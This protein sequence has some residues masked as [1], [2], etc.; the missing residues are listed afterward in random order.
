MPRATDILVVLAYAIVA[1][2]AAIAFDRFGLMSSELAWIMGAVVFLIAGQVHAAAARI[3]ERAETAR[4]I[5]SLKAAN[6]SLKRALEHAEARLDAIDPDGAR[7]IDIPGRGEG[8][9]TGDSPAASS[10]APA[11]ATKAVQAADSEEDRLIAALIARLEASGGLPAGAAR[12]AAKA[13]ASDA[14]PGEAT[15]APQPKPEPEIEP[16]AKAAADIREALD[17]NRVD[18]YLQPVVGLPQRR[19]YFYEGFTRLR[20]RSGAVIAPADFLAAAE[21]AGL[22]ADVDN[23]LLFRCV[24]I[25]RRLTRTDRRIGIFCN[26]SMRS[27]AD[28]TFFPEFLDFLR[29]NSDLAGSLIFELPHAAFEGRSAVAARNMA[30]LADYGFRFSIDQVRDLDID[31]AELQRAGVRF[32]KV[33][34]AVLLSAA[35][36]EIS[37]AGREPGAVAPED[38][39][40]VFARYGVD[41]VAEKIEAEAT[42]VEVLDLDIAYAQGHLFG[43][44]RPVREDVIAE[45]DGAQRQAG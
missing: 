24:Q 37:I 25:V 8:A 14:P 3:E 29:R 31:L 45:A 9:P 26:I 4:D 22:I 38:V 20:D 7:A 19:T 15:G 30:R 32:A 13:A 28:E 44:P 27:L 10:E 34:G 2:A 41:L 6:R 33:E 43:A 1:G 16:G 18:L 11:P 42:V 12:Q 40:G 17:E 23:L 5:K 35:R 21:A 36:G 39:A